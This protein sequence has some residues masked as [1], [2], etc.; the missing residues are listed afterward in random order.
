[1]NLST[2]I[3]QLWRESKATPVFS[4]LYIGGVTFA[5]GFTML[6][7]ILIYIDLIP[8]YPE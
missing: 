2:T 8:V 1:M 7:A 6:Y 3:K 5:V 4:A